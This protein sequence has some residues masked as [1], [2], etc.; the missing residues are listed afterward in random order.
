MMA[1]GCAGLAGGL[2]EEQSAGGGTGDWS[3]YSPGAGAGHPLENSGTGGKP[4]GSSFTENYT[5]KL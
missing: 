3:S 2:A 5:C 1:G 4:S